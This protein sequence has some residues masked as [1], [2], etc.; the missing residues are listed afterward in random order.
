MGVGGWIVD[1]C[2]GDDCVGECVVLVYWVGI[3]G[4]VVYFVFIVWI[5]VV[6]GWG[7][8]GYVGWRGGWVGD[9]LDICFCGYY[10][11]G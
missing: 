10:G 7:C 4:G 1:E 5:L 11:V 8:V 9:M 6:D 2:G 3:V